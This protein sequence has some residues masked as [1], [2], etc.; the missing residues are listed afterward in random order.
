MIIY[1]IE[2]I[3]LCLKIGQML[4]CQETNNHLPHH[5]YKFL[6]EKHYSGSLRV[7]AAIF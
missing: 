4:F 5:K 3:N 6:K 2:I 7:G 1:L